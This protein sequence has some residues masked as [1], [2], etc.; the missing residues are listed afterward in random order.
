MKLDIGNIRP[1]ADTLVVQTRPGG[2]ALDYSSSSLAL[3][4]GLIDGSEER[5]RADSA[6]ESARNLTI[7]YA[8]CYLGETLVEAMGGEWDFADPWWDSVVVHDGV[9]IRPFDLVQRRIDEGRD[10]VSFARL[11]RV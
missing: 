1:Y 4:E 10:A 2:I 7:F 3:L 6:N 5:L 9:R 8:G 11:V